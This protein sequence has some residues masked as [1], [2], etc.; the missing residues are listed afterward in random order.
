MQIPAGTRA[1]TLVT[2]RAPEFD[3]ILY[4]TLRVRKDRVIRFSDDRTCFTVASGK[5]F[6]RALNLALLRE[7]GAQTSGNSAD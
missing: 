1:T 7:R 6:D 4:L 5:V 2:F 3:T